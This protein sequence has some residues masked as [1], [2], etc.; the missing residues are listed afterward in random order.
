[1]LRLNVGNASPA[2][3][4]WL[5]KQ[6]QLTEL[7]LYYQSI[8]PE[9]VPAIAGLKGLKSLELMGLS[10]EELAGTNVSVS[11]SVVQT[12]YTTA[13]APDLK[14]PQLKRLRIATGSMLGSEEVLHQMLQS[15][16]L[17]EVQ[18]SQVELTDRLVADLCALKSLTALDL[19]RQSISLP[20]LRRVTSLPQVVSLNLQ[21]STFEDGAVDL[22]KTCKQLKI[23][24][25]RWTNLSPES[26]KAIC[27]PGLSL[28]ADQAGVRVMMVQ[29]G[30]KTVIRE[31]PITESWDENPPGDVSD[32]TVAQE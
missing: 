19:S 31:E 6:S 5:K 8:S 28:L 29:Q 23:L 27:R 1:M 21:G 20:H 32:G 12:T 22:L 4:K 7:C 13:S 9:V 16:A 15:P 14:F 18:L 26:V 24:N 3:A 17:T 30:G 2:L 25:M 11:K 10:A